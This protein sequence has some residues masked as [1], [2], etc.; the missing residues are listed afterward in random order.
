MKQEEF[1]NYRAMLAMTMSEL[2]KE[3]GIPESTLRAAEYR[4]QGLNEKY[5]EVL[6]EKTKARYDKMR[7]LQLTR[8]N[9]SN[10]TQKNI[11]ARHPAKVPYDSNFNTMTLIMANATT[12]SVT[13]ELVCEVLSKVSNQDLKN[14]QA[15]AR[16]LAKEKGQ[17]LNAVLDVLI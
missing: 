10:E 11:K 15:K 5:E 7:E 2:A 16:K 14:I 9:F 8:A 17:Q 4:K 3:T 1:R 13:L 6:Y 12:S